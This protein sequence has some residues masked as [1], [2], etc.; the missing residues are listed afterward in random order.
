LLQGPVNAS[1]ANMIPSADFNQLARNSR[2]LLNIHQ[3]ESRYFE[4]HRLFVSGI[5]EGCV[6]VT[7]PCIDTG[8][9]TAGIHFLEIEAGLMG[10]YVDWLLL[11]VEGKQKMEQ[12]YHSCSGFRDG[13]I[14]IELV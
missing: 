13:L 14:S 3:G 9:L 8:M 10:E 4:W 5:C 2:I 1:S 6:V 12:V 11:T 7:E